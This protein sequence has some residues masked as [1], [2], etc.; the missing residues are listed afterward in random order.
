MERSRFFAFVLPACFE[1]RSILWKKLN[2]ALQHYSAAKFQPVKDEEL[3]QYE[4][5]HEGRFR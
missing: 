1:H 5:N 4:D 2:C 3:N